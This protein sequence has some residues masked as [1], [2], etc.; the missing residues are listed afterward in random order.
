MT[1]RKAFDGSKKEMAVRDTIEVKA[2]Q[3]FKSVA[4]SVPSESVLH[5]LRRPTRSGHREHFDASWIIRP[6]EKVQMS[7]AKVLNRTIFI[8]LLITIVLTAIPYGATQAWWE[9][10]FESVVFVLGA[11]WLVEMMLSNK[12][13]VRGWPMLLPLGLLALFAYLQTTNLGL[14][15]GDRSFPGSRTISADP[16]ATWRFLLKF[17]ALIVAGELLLIYTSSSRRLW[18]LVHTLIGLGLGSALFGLIRRLTQGD[19]SSF[20]LPG[21]TPHVGYAQFINQNHFAF[22]IEMALALVLASVIYHA[23]R[24]QLVTVYVAAALLMWSSLVFSNSRGGLLAFLAQLIFFV[25]LY[26]RLRSARNVEGVLR[27]PRRRAT[28]V[29]FRALLVTGLLATGFAISLWVGGPQLEKRLGDLP[30]EY[31]TNDSGN[32]SYGNRT[33]IWRAAWSLFREHPWMG[34]GFGG[35]QTAVP[36]THVASGEQMLSVAINDYLEI[37][38]SAGVVGAVLVG[39]FIFGFVYCARDS[40]R[41]VDGFRRM[42]S[43]GALAG[44]GAIAVHSAVEF[45]LHTNINALVFAGLIA[46][47]T[48]DARVE[49]HSRGGR[50]AHGASV[51]HELS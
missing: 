46:I 11:L 14:P 4:E 21:L 2:N 51:H 13:E 8:S 45:G 41:S 32:A 35:F 27:N 20:V 34:V 15:G 33:E 19:Q 31:Q 50:W 49:V 1:S 29:A 26:P 23:R 7:L 18:A 44:L 40:L 47:G 25:L 38:A 30:K 28:K 36:G 48:T 17:L 43:C 42:T 10:I 39:I 9:S 3:R 6:S 24:T 37:L 22:L 16:F 12:W 5:P